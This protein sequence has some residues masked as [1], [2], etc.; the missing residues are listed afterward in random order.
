MMKAIAD[1]LATPWR[2]VAATAV[3]LVSGGLVIWRSH[4]EATKPCATK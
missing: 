2:L 1:L 4:T 3:V